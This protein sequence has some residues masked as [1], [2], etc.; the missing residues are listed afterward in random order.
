MNIPSEILLD[1][2]QY[3][4]IADLKQIELTCTEWGKVG[5]EVMYTNRVE[6]KDSSMMDVKFLKFIGTVVNNK[7]LGAYVKSSYQKDSNNLFL[8]ASLR[9]LGDHC[10]HIQKI[11][12]AIGDSVFYKALL[13]EVKVGKFKQLRNLPSI[14]KSRRNTQPTWM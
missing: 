8:T 6:F 11:M 9:I 1:I 7:K 14:L 4:N 3:L 12:I 2:F 5:Q 10:P 13:E